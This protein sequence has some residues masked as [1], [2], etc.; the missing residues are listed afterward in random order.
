MEWAIPMRR[1]EG[2][3]TREYLLAHV[4]EELHVHDGGDDALQGA[5]LGVDA[6]REEHEEEEHRPEGGAGELVDGLG[7]RD[8][9][10]ARARRALQQA[11]K[12]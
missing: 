5:E 6:Q 2:G 8:E 10:Q 3:L 1:E 7:E 11:H 4:G 9:G 12:D